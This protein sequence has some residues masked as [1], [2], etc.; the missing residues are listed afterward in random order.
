MSRKRRKDGGDN[1]RHAPR[2]KKAKHKKG[3]TG[4]QFYSAK[5]AALKAENSDLTTEVKR[6]QARV[7]PLC[8]A[9]R[10]APEGCIRDIDLKQMALRV[11]CEQYTDSLIK[12]DMTREQ[13]RYRGL[14]GK[15][16]AEENINGFLL[17]EKSQLERDI[18]GL[19]RRMSSTPPIAAACF[20]L[21]PE[22]K[23]VVMQFAPGLFRTACDKRVIK[24][25]FDAAPE[26]VS[27]PAK[28]PGS[29]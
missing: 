21:V 26:A 19:T 8:V 11:E 9:L 5:I 7:M 10:V 15:L 23:P 27:A 4:H 12:S 6:L 28:A 17:T 16:L 25:P 3:H 29:T 13:V 2:K 24:R 18:V 22:G 1:E 20:S 14:R